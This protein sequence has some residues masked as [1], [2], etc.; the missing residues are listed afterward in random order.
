M[1]RVQQQVDVAPVPAGELVQR[2]CRDG[3]LLELGELL[4]GLA[5][6]RV[7]QFA[8]QARAFGDKRLEVCGVEVVGRFV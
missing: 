6:A 5:V 8:R 7:A 2:P 1:P 4:G 3:R